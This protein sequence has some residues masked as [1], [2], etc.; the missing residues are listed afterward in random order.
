MSIMF[1]W[2]CAA[3]FFLLLEAF[4]VTL[5]G[6]MIALGCLAAGILAYFMGDVWH[7]YQAVLCLVVVAIGSF[8]VPRLFHATGTP[9]QMGLDEYI[10]QK[11]VIKIVD[12]TTKVTLGGVDRLAKSDKE[13]SE[14]QKVT[15][16]GRDG[17]IL[18]V[19]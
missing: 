19:K 2:F 7:W 15:I 1:L 14:G 8:F 9:L 18:I 5:Y 16:M 17:I 11:A 13:L 12:S 3:L 4:T 6:L 10:G